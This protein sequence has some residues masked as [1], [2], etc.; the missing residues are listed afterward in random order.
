MHVFGAIMKGGDITGNGTRHQ[1]DKLCAKR[2]EAAS[3]NRLSG[4]KSS[5]SAADK[6]N[7]SV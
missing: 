2:G 4:V 6:R 5:V 3:K 1:S 7:K